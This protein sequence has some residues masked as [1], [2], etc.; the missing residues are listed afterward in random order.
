MRK[1][2]LALTLPGLT[3]DILSRSGLGVARRSQ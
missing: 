3:T 1:P 2:I